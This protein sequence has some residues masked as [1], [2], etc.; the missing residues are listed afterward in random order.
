MNKKRTIGD[1]GEDIA[2]KYLEEKGYKIIKRNYFCR[3][4]ELDIIAQDGDSLV[5]AEVKT[6]RSAT[7]GRASEFVDYEKQQ[8]IIKTGLYYIGSDDYAFRFDVIEVYYKETPKG[9]EAYE[10]NHIENAFS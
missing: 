6:R 3:T 1:F 10:I 5:F 8:K 7:F 2:V 4:G 9:F